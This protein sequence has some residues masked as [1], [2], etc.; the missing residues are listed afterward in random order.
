MKGTLKRIG[1][2]D[3]FSVLFFCFGQ[4]AFV[5]EQDWGVDR[6]FA[7]GVAKVVESEST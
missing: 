7:W 3:P 1:S 4:C 5:Q 2:L 6:L